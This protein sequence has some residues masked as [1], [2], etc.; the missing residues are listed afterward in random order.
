MTEPMI[1][2]TSDEAAEYKTGLSGWVSRDGR[3]YGD[4]ERMARWAGATHVPCRECGTPTEK[5]WVICEACRERKDDEKYAARPR[6]AWA[7]E[8]LYSE[9]TDRWFFD[10][11][12]L[13]DYC[14]DEQVDRNDLRLII[15]EPVYAHEIDPNEYYTDELPEDGEVDGDLADAFDALNALIRE[16]RKPLSWKP[17]KFAATFDPSAPPTGAP[18]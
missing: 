17:G 18:R 14:E 12:S 4:D 6:Q 10:E 16:R 13:D 7:G 11:G 8:P 9:T 3:Y 15:C 2:S 5:G 1:L